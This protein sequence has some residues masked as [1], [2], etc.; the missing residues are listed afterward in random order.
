ML[1]E[2][3]GDGGVIG[4]YFI[5]QGWTALCE[6]TGVELVDF[7]HDE[8]CDYPLEDAMYLDVVRLPKKVV[9]AD[10]FITLPVLKNHGTVCVTA[11]VKNSFGLIPAVDRRQT[12]RYNAIEQC[13]TDIARVRK[14]DLT[15]VDGRIG[16][17][18]ISGGSRFDHPRYA[19]RLVMGA[20]PV[21]VDVVC[22]H[23]MDQNPRV[24]YLQWCDY[25]GVGNANLDYVSIVGM[26]IEEAKMHFMTP[27]EEFE[28][29]TE[30][31]LKLTDLGSC[32]R[33]RAVAQGTLN[34]FRSPESVLNEV[35]ILYGPNDFDP[36]TLRERCILIGDCIKEKYRHLGIWVPGCPMDEQAY[37]E[38]LNK[39]NVVCNHCEKAV[40]EFLA[41]HSEEELAFLRILASNKTVYQ[42]ADNKSDATDYVMCVGDCQKFYAN[43]HIKRSAQEIATRGLDIDINDIVGCVPGHKPTAEVIEETFQKLRAH[44]LANRQ[45]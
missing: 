33:C 29:V 12:H 25:Y 43:R 26:S 11:A 37:F 35:E 1:G 13:L 34:R 36:S 31:K 42:G 38:A 28:E 23:I 41:R 7:E 5:N 6:S 19:N 44:Y 17:E 40:E 8:W 14:P 3:T 2:N 22:A 27:A 30:G 24:R 20:D 21:A 32:S 18:G 39:L 10:V 4:P 9:E 45:G 16:M 15:I